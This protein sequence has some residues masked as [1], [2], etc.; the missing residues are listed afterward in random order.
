MPATVT[1]ISHTPEPEKLIAAAGKLCYSNSPATELLNGLGEEKTAYFVD[2]LTSRGHMSTLEHASFTFAV[3]GVS[4]SLLA[5]ITR[6]RI[7]SFSVQ[8]QRYVPLRY[9]GHVVPREIE[10]NDEAYAEYSAAMQSAGKHYNR[11]ANILQETHQKRLEAEGMMPKEALSKARKLAIED[12]RAVLPNSCETK[13]MMTMNAR[14]LHNFFALRCCERAQAE[15]RA[16]AELMLVE[17]RAAA[18]LL[19]AKAGPPCVRGNCPEASMS[20]GKAT[21]M[22]K[23]YA[24][25]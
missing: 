21:E 9:F 8:S 25:E 13:M 4:R 23:R 6:H 12:A 7:A 1:L 16:L 24:A 10:E 20:C 19:F 22:R 5:Q 15:I 3:E 18:P 11:I 17:A 2:M 14:S